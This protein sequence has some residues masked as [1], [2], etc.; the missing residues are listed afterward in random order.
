[1][2][3]KT[4]MYRKAIYSTLEV[5][6]QVNFTLDKNNKNKSN[7]TV[8]TVFLTDIFIFLVNFLV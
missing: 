5:G 3:H 7:F 6:I 8:N 4:K 1:M 2:E